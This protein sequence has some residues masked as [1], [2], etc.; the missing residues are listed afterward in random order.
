[1]FVCLLRSQSCNK[2]F[3]FRLFTNEDD[4]GD[5]DDGFGGAPKR[6]ARRQ[7]DFLLRNERRVCLKN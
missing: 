2:C 7:E 6:M 3:T 5:D 1:M 4:R